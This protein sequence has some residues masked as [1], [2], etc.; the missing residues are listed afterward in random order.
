MA[1][2]SAWLA[3]PI[4]GPPFQ[5]L[6]RAA[7]F[8]TVGS[9]SP[10]KPPSCPIS[11]KLTEL[12]AITCMDKHTLSVHL[13]GWSRD[14]NP[15]GEN[16]L[17]CVTWVRVPLNTMQVNLIQSQMK[18][19]AEVRTLQ[20]WHQWG[21]LTNCCCRDHC[22][23][24]IL[25]P[26]KSRACECISPGERREMHGQPDIHL[27]HVPN[28][29]VIRLMDFWCHTVMN[30]MQIV[31]HDIIYMIICPCYRVCYVISQ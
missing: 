4:A 7:A 13:P 5:G 10:G 14:L 17:H 12:W 21:C 23:C 18:T 2:G 3:M 29:C 28:M 15:S 16:Q 31:M 27:S 11:E 9:E 22:S 25:Q 19:D 30:V 1:W 26:R 20:H 8:G 24:P 6:L